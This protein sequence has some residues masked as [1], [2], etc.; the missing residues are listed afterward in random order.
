[1]PNKLFSKPVTNRENGIKVVKIYLVGFSIPG[2]CCIF[3]NNCFTR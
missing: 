1:M 3:C 2:S